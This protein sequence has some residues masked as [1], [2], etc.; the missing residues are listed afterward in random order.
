MLMASCVSLDTAGMWLFFFL[1]EIN[2][3]KVAQ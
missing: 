2:M 1:R 3:L